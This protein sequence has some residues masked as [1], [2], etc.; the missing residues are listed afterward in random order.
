MTVQIIQVLGLHSWLGQFLPLFLGRM[1]PRRGHISSLLL[2][3]VMN[4]HP[5]LGAGRLRGP[6]RGLAVAVR[7]FQ[8]ISSGGSLC[9]VTF[10]G[11]V[12]AK[13]LVVASV[14]LRR[15]RERHL[16]ACLPNDIV[17]YTA[18][19]TMR[20]LAEHD[21]WEPS[22]LATEVGTFRDSPFFHGGTA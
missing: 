7:Y 3:A 10:L 21:N 20:V 16:D 15:E 13:L 17:P 6:F 19:F 4:A 5:F 11:A 14:C 1:C 2:G 8:G 18:R 9:V 22:C 12:P